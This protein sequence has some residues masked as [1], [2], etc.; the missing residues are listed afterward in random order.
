MWN[1][2]LFSSN[3]S[4]YENQH[5]GKYYLGDKLQIKILHFK[6]YLPDLVC[7]IKGAI[8]KQQLNLICITMFSLVWNHLNI[9]TG[10]LAY[11]HAHLSRYLC[12][13]IHRCF[14]H[15][16]IAVISLGRFT[17]LLSLTQ[18]LVVEDL[19]PMGSKFLPVK[20]FSSPQLL[21]HYKEYNL[22]LLYLESAM[23]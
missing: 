19:P 21:G 15:N 23:W 18:L 2:E 22:D 6:C 8:L 4:I 13:K 12:R 5:H 9:N 7:K 10:H 3:E 16:I 20:G 17:S 11:Y 14:W 1:S